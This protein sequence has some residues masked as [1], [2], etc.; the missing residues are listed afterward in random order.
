MHKEARLDATLIHPRWYAVFVL[1]LLFRYSRF[2]FLSLLMGCVY[3]IFER[4]EATNSFHEFPFG[5]SFLPVASLFPCPTSFRSW[6]TLADRSMHHHY[7]HTTNIFCIIGIYNFCD[8]APVH[9]THSNEELKQ[10]YKSIH[11]G[12]QLG[13]NA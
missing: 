2:F 5:P 9:S 8:A 4:P 6:R 1:Y 7:R 10:N 3:G 11:F 12:G 13:R